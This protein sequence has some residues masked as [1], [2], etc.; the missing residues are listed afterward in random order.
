MSVDLPLTEE[1]PKKTNFRDWLKGRPG[2][3]QYLWSL[4]SEAEAPTEEKLTDCFNRLLADSGLLPKEEFEIVIPEFDFDENNDS[5]SKI[6]LTRISD[7]KQVNAIDPDCDIPFAR[8]LT[9]I[10]GDNGSGKSG[11]GRLL[12]NACN[13]RK[14]RQLLPDARSETELE[15]GAEA[16]F[17]IESNGAAQIVDYKFG[18]VHPMLK[19]FSV[20]DH[21]CATI[22]LNSENKVEFVPAKLQVFDEVFNSIQ[23]L[24]E[25]LAT[26]SAAKEVQN[27]IEGVFPHL[28]AVKS[29][30]D[31]ISHTTSDADIQR[32]LEFT[33]DDKSS[34]I[35]AKKERREK[36]QQNIAKEKKELSEAQITLETYRKSLQNS[37]APLTPPKAAEINGLIRVIKERRELVSQLSAE[38]FEFENFNHVGSEEWKAL[39]L[40]A[41]KLHLKETATNGGTEPTNCVLCRQPIGKEEKSLFNSYWDF[42]KSTAEQE[43]DATLKK[44][45]ESSLEISL[46]Y[47]S[48][49]N[50]ST[51][52]I[53]VKILTEED[54]EGFKKIEEQF[55]ILKPK[56]LKWIE[57]IRAEEVVEEIDPSINLEAITSVIQKKKETEASLIDPT[58]E[59]TRLGNE[60]FGLA[61]KERA[62]GLIPKIKEYVA[63]L[64]W[65]EAASKINLP[66][67]R[68][69]LTIKKND[70]MGELVIGRYIGLFNDET[71][72]LDC[73]FGLTVGSRGKDAGTVKALKLKFAPGVAPSDILSEGEQTVSALADFLT[74]AKLNKGN[75]G[76]IFD[77]PVNSLDHRRRETIAKR[78][79]TE[80]KE[81]QVIIL[82]HDVVFL[83]MLQ[84]YSNQ[85][86]VDT[87]T[88][89]IRKF[90]DRIG[91]IK[92]ELPEIAQNLKDR[93]K[94]L[95]N[96]LVKLKGLE[97]GDPDEY[98]KEVKAWY[99]LL[100]EGW[101][102]AI[103][104]RVVQNVVRRLSSEVQP[105]RVKKISITDE[106][107]SA[108][109]AGMN[110]AGPWRH[111]QAQAMNLPTPAYAK[112]EE[113][114]EALNIFEDTYKAF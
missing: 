67:V 77:D 93:V 98:R 81:R 90:G 74:E 82:T 17:H 28:S 79:A 39:I 97:T 92:P 45:K 25:R 65:K 68:R 31:T 43:L 47:N 85:L 104:E 111:N 41:H 11:I 103:E 8:G 34:F 96:D 66:S 48:L 83:S 102:R 40:A 4:H 91:I 42:L 38:T 108:L 30:L 2:W 15:E 26:E 99:G 63:W 3:E 88:L 84:D 69:S 109:E 101:E 71:E 73:S 19:A 76:I 7:L 24:E 50:F 23:M 18:E 10:Y 21:E 94:Y 14:P 86:H 36:E 6:F 32:N 9:V 89:S 59:I 75:A 112:L 1:E 110:E 5:A 87:K 95:R 37:I 13:S 100:Y 107:K 64:R 22:H 20:F 53:A 58:P 114:L 113:S 52:L 106:M 72:A 80:A 55:S 35:A 29:F 62:S 51:S 78:L 27:P 33:A 12:S 16:K 44:L 57:N 54:P 61:E 49:P 60:I 105:R 70:L 46:I 56:V